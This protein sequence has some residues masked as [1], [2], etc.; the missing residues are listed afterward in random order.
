MNLEDTCSIKLVTYRNWSRHATCQ[1]YKARKSKYSRASINRQF[2]SPPYC[3]CQDAKVAPYVTITVMCE[4]IQ[5]SNS[6]SRRIV[7]R[8]I[9][10][11][12]SRIALVATVTTEGELR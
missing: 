2:L 5:S 11:Q 10:V 3:N 7:T 8:L 6:A 12:A 9:T 1:Q 4:A